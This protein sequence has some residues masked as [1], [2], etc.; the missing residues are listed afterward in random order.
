MLSK[1]RCERLRQKSRRTVIPRTLNGSRAWHLFEYFLEHIPL[2]SA[3]FQ[4]PASSYSPPCAQLAARGRTVWKSGN[5]PWT[6]QQ[7]RAV[8][9]SQAESS[10]VSSRCPSPSSPPASS[11]GCFSV[12]SQNKDARR[13]GA[14]FPWGSHLPCKPQGSTWER[15]RALLGSSI[16]TGQRCTRLVLFSNLRSKISNVRTSEESCGLRW[17]G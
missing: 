15:A 16:W 13:A 14:T 17:P 11:C 4:S 5:V 1:R 6:T 2:P 8:P 3:V 7:P 12:P 10:S 9:G